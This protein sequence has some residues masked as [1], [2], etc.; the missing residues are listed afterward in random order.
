MLWQRCHKLCRATCL[1]RERLPTARAGKG[2]WAALLYRAKPAVRVLLRLWRH[3]A[4]GS[5]GQLCCLGGAALLRVAQD[6]INALQGLEAGL[7]SLRPAS[8]TALRQAARQHVHRSARRC[9]AGM[10]CGAHLIPRTLVWV[11]AQRKRPV[12]LLDVCLHERPSVLIQRR[13]ESE[14]LAHA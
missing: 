14:P 2:G 3:L 9:S 8:K 7:G 6:G 5:G 13:Q 11:A 4:Q 12:R 10:H 1:T